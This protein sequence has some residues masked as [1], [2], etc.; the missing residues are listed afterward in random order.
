LTDSNKLE[1]IQRKFAN[2]FHYQF[3]QFVIPRNYDFI[4]NC[5]NFRTLYSRRRLLDA[6]SLINTFKSKINCHSTMDTI[7]IRVPTRQIRDFS[8]FSA[9]SA[10]RLSP[11]VRCASAA[12]D[13]CR[14]LDIFGKDIVSFEDTFCLR[15]SDYIDYYTL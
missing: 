5:L 7:G 13:I 9:S 15:E 12:N 11:K 6:L 3:L 2:L 8:T 1:S 14:L 10:L 4:L